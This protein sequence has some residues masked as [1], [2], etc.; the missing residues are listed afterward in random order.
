MLAEQ[1]KET[2]ILTGY[3]LHPI[4]AIPQHAKALQDHLNM[5]V[6]SSPRDFDNGLEMRRPKFSTPIEIPRYGAR[7]IAINSPAL[8]PRT[9]RRNMLNVE[10]TKSLR[11]QLVRERRL[12]A[13]AFLKRRYT[14]LDTANVKQYPEQANMESIDQYSSH[15]FYTRGW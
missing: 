14:S 2:K 6:I 1:E 9:T 10:L 12:T 8:S 11:L 15:D 7:P 3:A 13:N 4:P 5:R